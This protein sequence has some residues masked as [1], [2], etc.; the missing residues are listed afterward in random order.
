ME[1]W[2]NK[3][4]GWFKTV[5]QDEHCVIQRLRI[6]PGGY[7]SK[8]RHQRLNNRMVVLEGRFLLRIWPD[9]LLDQTKEHV[10]EQGDQL[11][12]PSPVVHRFRAL[13]AVEAI[14][15]VTAKEGEIDLTDIERFD[16]GGLIQ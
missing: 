11:F 8:H 3:K 2:V 16:Q 4:W 1:G 7:S 14:E 6:L 9:N 13:E 5:D 10:L 12:I 15:I